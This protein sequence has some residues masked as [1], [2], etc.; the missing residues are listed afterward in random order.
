M[1]EQRLAVQN[2]EI[3]LIDLLRVLFKRKIMISVITLLITVLSIAVCFVLPQKFDVTTMLQIGQIVSAGGSQGV[4]AVIEAPT[5]LKL[6]IEDVYLP[7]AKKKMALLTDDK[8]ISGATLVVKV[9][10]G[11]NLLVLHSKATVADREQVDQLHNL[12]V[13]QIV[14]DHKG[15]IQGVTLQNEAVLAQGNLQLETLT[16]PILMSLIKQRAQTA[17]DTAQ[18]ELLTLNETRLVLQQRYQNLEK[19]KKLLASQVAQ[20]KESLQISLA[21]RKTA[22]QGLSSESAALTLLMLDDQIEKDRTRLVAMQDRLLFQ[23]EESAKKIEGQLAD[24]LRKI[25]LKKNKVAEL[26]DNMTQQLLNATHAQKV[27]EQKIVKLTGEIAQSKN[28]EPLAVAL[29]SANPISPKKPLIV[30]L[31]FMLGFMGSV[32]LAFLLEY[33]RQH[34][35][36]FD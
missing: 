36:D 21:N 14:A 1:E 25:T 11:S 29:F 19:R 22:A 15:K 33:L 28:T 16:N 9:P 23:F 31:G 8:V 26:Q 13:A 17:I 27:Q 18:N 4:P 20:L 6:K 30:A 34:K 10:K 24:N 2:D 7:L 5:S 12:V 32:M 35:Q 3:E